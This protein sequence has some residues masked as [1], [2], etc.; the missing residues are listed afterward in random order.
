MDQFFYLK[1]LFE[2]MEA[3]AGSSKETFVSEILYALTNAD[4]CRSE[5]LSA[6]SH[7]IVS[8]EPGKEREKIHAIELLHQSIK[9]EMSAVYRVMNT[10]SDEGEVSKKSYKAF[11]SMSAAQFVHDALYGML[12][13]D[14]AETRELSIHAL[15]DLITLF[16]WG[17]EGNFYDFEVPVTGSYTD[18]A[19][20][21]IV[22]AAK[23]KMPGGALMSKTMY[24]RLYGDIKVQ[25]LQ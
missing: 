21:R 13:D 2:C 20:E 11:I 17:T 3:H 24:W 8:M 19:F 10:K 5:F 6:L 9:L 1:V 25:G 18:A 4:A 7:L 23:R 22:D 16:V 12:I 14:E 15:V